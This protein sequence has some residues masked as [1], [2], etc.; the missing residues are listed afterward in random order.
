MK[1]KKNR[2]SIIGPDI[3][4]VVLLPLMVTT[5]INRNSQTVFYCNT[6]QETCR[7]LCM[8]WDR[9]LNGSIYLV[10]LHTQ[11]F[12][13]LYPS[14]PAA[15]L[16]CGEWTASQSHNSHPA[17]GCLCGCLCGEGHPSIPVT[18]SCHHCT[19]FNW[20]ELGWWRPQAQPAH[21]KLISLSC[22]SPAPTILLRNKR[23]VLV[24]EMWVNRERL[25]WCHGGKMD[26]PDAKAR[27]TGIYLNN[28][29]LQALMRI[30]VWQC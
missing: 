4:L 8:Q 24:Q 16:T 10:C 12:V 25:D 1:E 6:S 14:P 11:S 22:L 9:A 19:G 30:F 28:M 2:S 20:K 5:K 21:S 15:S 27:I 26:T 7:E 29:W 13:Q 18:F 3:T 23:P 17:R